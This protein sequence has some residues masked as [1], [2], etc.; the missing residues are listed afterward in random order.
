MGL[1][2][3][4]PKGTKVRMT[5]KFLASTGQ[6]KGSEGMSRWT[7]T[8]CVV[9]SIDGYPE[10]G[11]CGM[12]RDGKHVCT[13]ESHSAA[14]DANGYEDIPEALR[15]QMKRHIHIGNLEI[16]GAKPKAEDYDLPVVK[17]YRAGGG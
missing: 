10:G 1:K 12:C 9:G 7:V 3:V 2:V 8:D 15:K 14:T 11:P 6:V 4:P 17:V 5:A 16:V 13:D